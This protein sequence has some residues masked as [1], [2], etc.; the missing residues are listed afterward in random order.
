MRTRHPKSPR[1]AWRPSI[2]LHAAGLDRGR[3]EIGACVPEDRDAQP[4]R[5]FGTFPP[6]R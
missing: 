4:V 3:E 5:P 2:N 6:D 1:P